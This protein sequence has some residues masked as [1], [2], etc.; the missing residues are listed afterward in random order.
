MEAQARDAALSDAPV[1]WLQI[2]ASAGS[3]AT[4]AKAAKCRKWRLIAS[5]GSARS[6]CGA[7]GAVPARSGH[8]FLIGSSLLMVRPAGLRTGKI[9]FTT[10]RDMQIDDSTDTASPPP[11]PFSIL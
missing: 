8:A 7:P 6:N 4:E 3:T 1:R 5:A 2:L 11:A 10:K 9:H